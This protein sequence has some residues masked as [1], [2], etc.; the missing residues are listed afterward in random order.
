MARVLL[1]DDDAAA[2]GLAANALRADGHAVT[3]AA[4][5]L[6]ALERFRATPAAFDLVITDVQMPGLDGI[7]LVET[8]LAERAGTRAVLMSALA[9][10]L[11]RAEQLAARGVGVLSKPYTLDSLKGA[12]RKAV[13]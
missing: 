6:E 8:V 11:T 5:G 9:G 12:V 2:L 10:E 7:A 4:D 3:T 1:V 13:G